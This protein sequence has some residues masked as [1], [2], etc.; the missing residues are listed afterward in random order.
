MHPS[1]QDVSPQTPHKPIVESLQ[2]TLESPPKPEP[3]ATNI[4]GASHLDTSSVLTDFS[5]TKFT[6]TKFTVYLVTTTEQPVMNPDTTTGFFTNLLNVPSKEQLHAEFSDVFEKRIE[7]MD[8]TTLRISLRPNAQLPTVTSS[9]NVPLA[10]GE[11]LRKILQ[12]LR[13]EMV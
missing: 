5:L 9:R 8:G 1:L 6:M 2:P 7:P 12:E 10:Y 13:K 4:A 3:T 11:K